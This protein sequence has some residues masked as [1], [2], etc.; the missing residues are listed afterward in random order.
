MLKNYFLIV[1]WKEKTIGSNLRTFSFRSA[2]SI[3][4]TKLLRAV[5]WVSTLNAKITLTTITKWNYTL[6]I[7][8]CI[9]ANN[10]K[11]KLCKFLCITVKFHIHIHLLNYPSK[12]NRFSSCI[13]TDIQ[14]EISQRNFHY[15]M[16]IPSKLNHKILHFVHNNTK[17]MLNIQIEKFTKHCAMSN[18]TK[19]NRT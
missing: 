18:G 19:K 12:T 13:K 7:H 4:S 3:I 1:W 16:D 2:M 17:N 14:Y 15:A 11:P 6:E 8:L 10:I 5:I 9:Y